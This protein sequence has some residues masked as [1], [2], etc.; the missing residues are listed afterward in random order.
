MSETTS[1]S[2]R[3]NALSRASTSLVEDFGR[4]RPLRAG[5]LLIS[6]FGDAIAPH[7][8][9]VWLGSLI[10]ALERFGVNQRLVRTSVFRLVRDGWLSAE[11]VGRRSFYQLTPAG[12][13]RFATASERIYSAP[14]PRETNRWCLAL[15]ADVEA[16]QR[17]DLRRELKWL[18]F[19]PLSATLMVH[20]VARD[21]DIERVLH[22]LPGHER[23]VVLH[24]TAATA[25]EDAWRR[26]IGEAFDV[27]ALEGRYDAFITRFRTALAAAR[28][29]KRIDPGDAF[30]LRTLLIHEYRKIVLR[31]P[32]LPASVL[33]SPWHGLRAYELCRALYARIAPP[34]EHYLM[35]NLENRA[36]P[37]PPA[38]ARFRGRFDGL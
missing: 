6:I 30:V 24:A 19:A 4:Q 22:P 28:R 8:G 12:R 34:A 38:H 7:G 9:V 17:D 31:D 35:S 29:V 3:T 15:L 14:S 21:S 25:R 2:S 1:R 16:A 10:G 36:G 13:E 20:P 5:S 11:Q 26:L 18:G 23:V 33:P 27:A 32:M 37:L